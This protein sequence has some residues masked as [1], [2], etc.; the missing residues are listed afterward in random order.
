MDQGR[1]AEMQVLL[2]RLKED[3]VSKGVVWYYQ[4]EVLRRQP[5]LEDRSE[6]IAAYRHALEHEDAPVVTHRSLGLLLAKQD[7]TTAAR[8]AFRNYLAA[9][10]AAEDRGIIEYY[11][12]N[13]EKKP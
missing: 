13:L 4:G 6:A 2:D 7:D 5:D 11:L 12:K 1:F 10:P 3:D 8:A 9:A